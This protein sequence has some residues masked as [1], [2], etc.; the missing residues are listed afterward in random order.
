MISKADTVG[1]RSETDPDSRGSSGESS[2]LERFPGGSLARRRRRL[3]WIAAGA[4]FVA[5][6][7]LVASTF[8]R[9]PADETASAAPPHPSVLTATVAS[10][11]VRQT[12]VLRGTVSAEHTYDI[13]VSAAAASAQVVT[14]IGP[15]AGTSVSLG[16]VLVEISARPIVALSGPKPAYRDLKP[17]DTGIDVAQL[18]GSL[19]ALGFAVDGDKLGTYGTRTADAVGSFY[20][21]RGYTPLM[22]G[23]PVALTAARNDLTNA[24]SRIKQLRSAGTASQADLDGAVA[25]LND[26]RD[27]A[28]ALAAAT[29]PMVPFAEYVFLPTYPAVIVT[30]T[31]QL[32]SP[33]PSP[34]LRIAAGS[35]VVTGTLNSADVALVRAGMPATINGKGLTVTATVTSVGAGATSVGAG[36]SKKGS[37]P[38]SSGTSNDADAGTS[39]DTATSDGARPTASSSGASANAVTVTPDSA[40]PPASIG[41]DVQITIESASSTNAVLAVP[42]AAITA[43]ADGRT[44]VTVQRADRRHAVEVHTGISGGGVVAVTAADGQLAAGDKVITGG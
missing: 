29:G 41:E 21:S 27:R 44:Y 13:N 40:L 4:A 43:R 10:T 36:A 6:G 20:A 5:A 9:S 16:D 26:A 39:N 22:A 1:E 3:S 12:V 23:D 38:P 25:A 30:S 14:A 2:S 17:G 31:A 8:I 24:Q 35:L 19:A 32:G 28:K 42:V 34:L 7:G 37:G 15:Q 33:P 11:V 18:Q